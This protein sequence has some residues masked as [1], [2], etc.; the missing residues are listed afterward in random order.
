MPQGSPAQCEAGVGNVGD[1]EK[2]HRALA[3]LSQYVSVQAKS[4]GSRTSR[5]T[6]SPA[7][8]GCAPIGNCNTVAR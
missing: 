5:L 2:S 1:I 4:E 7:A 8:T 6:A 3:A